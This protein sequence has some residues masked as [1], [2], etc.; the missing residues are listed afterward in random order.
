VKTLLIEPGSPWET[1]YVKS[2]NGKLR[3]ELLNGEIFYTLREAQVLIESWRLH[4]K[5]GTPSQLAGLLSAGTVGAVASRSR[6]RYG[7]PRSGS[8]AQELPDITVGTRRGGR[9]QETTADETR[10]AMESAFADA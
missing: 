7:T 6:L 9:S 2:F 10:K 8:P 1:G 3:D 4:Y 5:R